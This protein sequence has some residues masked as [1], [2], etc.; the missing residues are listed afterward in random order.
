MK[1]HFF[2]F[3]LFA[4]FVAFLPTFSMAKDSQIMK[5]VE[6]LNSTESWAEMSRD[7]F[8]RENDSLISI[9]QDLCQEQP[10]IIKGVIQQLL[11]IADENTSPGDALNNWSYVYLINRMYCQVP[12]WEKIENRR[13][14]GGWVGIPEDGRRFRLSYPFVFNADGTIKIEGPVGGYSG[15]AYQG[16]Q[17]FD[18]FMETY[19]K[20]KENIE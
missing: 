12:D 3:V 11:K 4:S 16:I 19:G 14:F 20:R 6:M 10:D 7:T 17:E 13:L 2:I 8:P 5:Y 18:F 9:I 15:A 1:L